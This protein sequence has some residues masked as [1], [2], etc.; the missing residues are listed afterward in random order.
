LRLA[1][2]LDIV[3]WPRLTLIAHTDTRL[4]YAATTLGAGVAL[5]LLPLLLVAVS[6]PVVPSTLI[7]PAVLFGHVPQALVLS[8]PPL[9]L[10]LWLPSLFVG[11][12]TVPER[13]LY[14]LLFITVFQFV[15]FFHFWSQAR[16]HPVIC[17]AVVLSLLALW[18]V[19]GIA[20][21]RETF[22]LTLGFHTATVVWLVTLGFPDFGG[23]P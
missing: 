23:W 12:F 11:G 10:W 2:E 7:L 5:G 13:S 4:R 8:I 14:G 3:R 20:S 19:G 6:W 17:V 16:Q 9:L 18:L 21:R 1:A 22:T 15:W